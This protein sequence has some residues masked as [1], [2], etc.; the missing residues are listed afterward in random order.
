MPLLYLNVSENQYEDK[1]ILHLN[2]ASD[3]KGKEYEA[4]I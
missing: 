1:K 2:N 3:K 4:E